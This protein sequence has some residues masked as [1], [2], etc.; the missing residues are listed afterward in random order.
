MQGRPTNAIKRLRGQLDESLFLA[1]PRTET[2]LN[3]TERALLVAALLALAIVLQV[4]RLGPSAGLD[5]LWAEDGQVFFQQALILDFWD[6]V[7]APYAGY[8]VLVPRLIGEV[9]NLVPLREAA[10]AMAIVTGL[11][12]ALCGLVVWIASAA[13]ISNPYLR[14]TLA[15]LTVL[16]PVAGLESVL[17]SAYVLWY[18]LFASF[19][20]LLW[21]PATTWGALLGSLFLLATALSTPGVW[22]F[23]PVAALRLLAARDGRDLL[24]VGSYAVG[25][26]IQV[27]VIANN[28]EAAAE[29]AWTNDIW[30]AYVQRVVDGGVLGE[31]LGG[32]AWAELGWPFLLVLLGCLAF[33]LV[34]AWRRSSSSARWLA[35]V[36]IPTSL[37]MFVASAYQR[38]VG[39]DMVWPAGMHG[40]NAGRYAIVPALLLV[41]AALALIDRLPQRKPGPIRIT[42]PSLAAVL[43]LLIGLASSFYV[44]DSAVRGTPSW[45]DALRRAGAT[46]VRDELPEGRVF[47]SPPGFG[48]VI[49]CERLPSP[50]AGPATR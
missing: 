46:C 47:I 43:I 41:S 4:L 42:W 36:A 50:S 28:S 12:I 40:G 14:G 25:A 45:G 1:A 9:G 29:P 18:M 19:W 7:F 16:A 17:S 49:P 15:A 23:A 20:L 34:L 2:P 11:V 8:L 37:L 3:W 39:T 27:P 5:S 31:T 38:A 44:G 6:T 22:F 30:T 26:A 48:V 10:G 35:A 24:L 13:H 21:R 33:A 32:G